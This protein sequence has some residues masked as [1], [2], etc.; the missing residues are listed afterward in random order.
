MTTASTSRVPEERDA[1]L[2]RAAL[3]SVR[4]ALGPEDQRGPHDPVHLR[5]DDDEG[6]DIVVPKAALD[7]FVHVLTNMA[8]GQGVT[9]VPAH[10]ELTTQQAADMLNVSRP[11]LIRLLQGGQIE[12]RTVGTHRRVRAESLLAYMRE[13]DR[14]REAAVDELS[15]MTQELGL[16]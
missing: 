3:V 7:L 16:A 8:A 10:A 5:V 11:F 14:D 12:Y 2:A 13:D 15:E 6:A 1:E 4:E 9:I